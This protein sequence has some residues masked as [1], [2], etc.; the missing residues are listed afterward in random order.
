MINKKT[1][2][3]L[4]LMPFVSYSG[5][6]DFKDERMAMLAEM[7]LALPD[8]GIKLVPRSTFNLTEEETR[9]GMDE[10][11]Q[12]KSKG[13]VE[14]D[15]TRPME[16]INFKAHAKSE[17]AQYSGISQ[18]KSTHLRREIKELKL[19]FK[20]TGVP[21]SLMINSIGIVPQGGFHEKGWSGA[22][23]FF[24][25]KNV[26]ICAY[27]EMNVSASHTAIQIALEDADYTVNDKLTLMKVRGNKASGYDYKIRWFDDIAFHELECANMNYSS[28]LNQAVIDLATQIDS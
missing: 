21:K 22:V 23:Q 9:I 27:A 25:T 24:E 26:G 18:D 17:Y 5:E 4:M 16:L 3:L 8:S 7:G 20:F 11:E 12:M 10:E 2:A 6:N 1:V 15:N 13:Y 14:E 28:Q 19:G